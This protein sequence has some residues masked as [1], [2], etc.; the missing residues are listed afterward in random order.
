MADNNKDV[1]ATIT[2]K[3]VLGQL[4]KSR[5]TTHIIHLK[6]NSYAIHKAMEKYFKSILDLTDRLAETHFGITGKKEIDDIPSS[7]YIDPSEHMNDISFYLNRN[8]AV[9][10]TSQEQNIIDEMLGLMNQI[11]YLLTLE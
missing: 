10:T 9:F 3:M 5:D 8:R 11:K 2:P 4:F 7:K 6:T 1:F